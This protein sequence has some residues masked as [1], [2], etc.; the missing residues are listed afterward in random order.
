[1]SETAKAIVDLFTERFG[2]RVSVGDTLSGI[3]TLEIKVDAWL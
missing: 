3:P 1:M 2:D